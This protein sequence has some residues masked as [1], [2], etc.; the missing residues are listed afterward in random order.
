[1]QHN[2]GLQVAREQMRRFKKA[3]AIA[4]R[5]LGAISPFIHASCSAAAL[6]FRETDFTLAWVGISMSGHR[7]SRETRLSWSIEDRDTGLQV[8]PVLTWEALGGQFQTVEADESVGYG[9]TWTARRP[10]CLAVVP[11]GYAD[12]YS[13]TLGNRS[14]V[15]IGGR[16]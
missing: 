13:R 2:L 8:Q 11:V 7:P 9:R 14:R 5:E 1:V 4:S 16:S 12:G 10:S 6:L 15:V 3:V